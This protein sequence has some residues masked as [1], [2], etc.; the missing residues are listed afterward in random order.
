MTHMLKTL[1]YLFKMNIKDNF[2]FKNY[3]LLAAPFIK[4]MAR[5][6]TISSDGKGIH[7]E[8]EEHKN[9]KD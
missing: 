7:E 8:K 9:K 1:S 5:V 3:P 2:E 4:Q 6:R